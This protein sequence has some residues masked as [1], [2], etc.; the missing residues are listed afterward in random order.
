MQLILCAMR[1]VKSQTYTPPF[2]THNLAVLYRDLSDMLTQPGNLPWQKYP[3]DH[4]LYRMGTYNDS[5]GE[6]TPETPTFLIHLIQ[7]KEAPNG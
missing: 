6:I 3:Q 1:D 7:V 4:E 2:S 5:T